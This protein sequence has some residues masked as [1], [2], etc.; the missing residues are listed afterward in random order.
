MDQIRWGQITGGPLNISQVS[1]KFL[2]YEVGSNLKLL[3]K[4]CDLKAI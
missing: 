1:L 4:V 3:N 2:S